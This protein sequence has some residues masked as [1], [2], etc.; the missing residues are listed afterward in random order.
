MCTP[1]KVHQLKSMQPQSYGWKALTVTAVQTAMPHV[2]HVLR[3]AAATTKVETQDNF[4]V[5]CE[6]I[7]CQNF[8]NTYCDLLK[9][10][11]ACKLIY[12]AYFTCNLM[13]FPPFSF[14]AG[15]TSSLFSVFDNKGSIAV[16]R[17]YHH[18][19]SPIPVL[20]QKIGFMPSFRLI[21]YFMSP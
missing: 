9:T 8:R 14:C 13:K 3:T 2:A 19:R 20:F 4:W 16:D 5:D 6:K 10:R 12:E 18:L 17:S 11:K 15:H 7:S 21:Y 1:L